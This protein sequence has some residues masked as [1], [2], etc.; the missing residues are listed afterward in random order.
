MNPPDPTAHAAFWRLLAAAVAR[1]DAAAE[2]EMVR[3]V[4]LATLNELDEAARAFGE[5][6]GEGSRA[7]IAAARKRT[8]G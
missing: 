7:I 6:S 2:G 1:A 4:E 8:L 3:S 5:A